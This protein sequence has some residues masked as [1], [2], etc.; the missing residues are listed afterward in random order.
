MKPPIRATIPVT[1]EHQ[2]HFTRGV[3]ARDN[4]LLRDLLCSN[5]GARPRRVL[6]VLDQ[7]LAASSPDLVNSVND[8][9]SA[10]QGCELVCPPLLE[11]GGEAVKNSPDTVARIHEAIHR[12]KL[13]R[14]SFVIAV[15]GGALLDA[16]GF[17]AAT[18]HRGMRHLR[19]PTTVLSQDDA[20]VGIKNGINLFGK[21]NFVGT[22]SP[23]AAVIDDFE[24]LASLPPREKR[25]GFIEAIK[26][27]LI[28]DREF[29]ESIESDAERL[30]QFESE[31]VENLIYRCAEAH[32]RHIATA[33]DPF[34]MGSARPL[35]FGHWAAHKLEQMSGFRIHHGEAVAI[36]IAIDVN[37]SRLAGF[38]AP[39]T[40]ERI[41]QLI[42]KLGFALWAEE[43]AE[44]DA[45]GELA[46]VRGLEEFREHLGGV[47]A[48]TL[49][50]DIGKGFEVHEMDAVK[51]RSAIQALRGE[52]QL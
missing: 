47:L 49:L 8:Y 33:G 12:L 40:A 46:V 34:E 11:P 14:H 51:I 5:N 50:R 32:V 41:L 3:F 2:V 21:K 27:A 39:A 10:A 26:V 1:F 48:I 28:R 43:L 45:S 20:G 30:R 31:A 38:L 6:V 36:G 13:C 37:Y 42:R 29:Y 25:A 44:T 17:A 19:I 16:V 22:F 9:F 23:P 35:D 15:G 7:N 18:A 24:M 52:N 4:R